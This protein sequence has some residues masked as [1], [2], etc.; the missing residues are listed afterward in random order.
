MSAE[1]TLLELSQTPKL[2]RYAA[3]LRE[4]NPKINLVSPSTLPELELRHIAD[5][6][7]LVAD[8]PETPCHVADVG[9][10]AGF[11]GLVLTTL[12]PHH[13]F[14]LIESDSRKAAFL[15]TVIQELQLKNV[16]VKNQRVEDVQL[17]P[18]AD[19]VTARAF[20]P[21]ERLL[22]QTRHLLH[23]KGAWLLLK[24][25]AVDI[26]L[27]ACETLFPMT[28]TVKPSKIML[29]ENGIERPAGVVVQ[30]KPS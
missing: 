7:Q 12:C 30:I 19:Y 11:P 23:E 29:K 15:M 2:K 17:S 20:A 26:E 14:T 5:S 13:T 28:T 3:L 16:Q 18:L 24:G 25:E 4:W 21:L 8:L 22:P 1:R 9:T 27:R 10:G 6:A